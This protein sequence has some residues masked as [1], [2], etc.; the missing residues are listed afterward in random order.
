MEM[1]R[2]LSMLP[3]TPFAYLIGGVVF[4]LALAGFA[5]AMFFDSFRSRRRA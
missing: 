2:D 4:A 1:L 5:L 3:L